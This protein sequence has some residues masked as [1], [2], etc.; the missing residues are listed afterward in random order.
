[1]TPSSLQ[2]PHRQ[3]EGPVLQK[4]LSTRYLVHPTKGSLMIRATLKDLKSGPKQ[5]RGEEQNLKDH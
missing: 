4:T 5:I 1:M 3:S 2:G